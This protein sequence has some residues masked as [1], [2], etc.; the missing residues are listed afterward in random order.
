LS[1]FPR[2]KQSFN[3]CF[4]Q[5][6]KRKI[7]KESLNNSRFIAITFQSDKFHQ[8]L[9]CQLNYPNKP[10]TQHRRKTKVVYQ[11]ILTGSIIL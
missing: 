11:K 8:I 4:V 1:K 9:V 10:D 6:T 3:N 7:A 2:S 5:Y